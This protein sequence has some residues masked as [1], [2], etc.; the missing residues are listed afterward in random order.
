M[1][2]PVVATATFSVPTVMVS[3]FV[4]S[5]A[6]ALSPLLRAIIA[7]RMSSTTATPPPIFQVLLLIFFI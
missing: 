2:E 5:A 7:N 1:I 6:D 4:V 3:V